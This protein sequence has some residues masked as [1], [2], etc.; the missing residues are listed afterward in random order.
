M[1]Y[2]QLKKRM[3]KINQKIIINNKILEVQQKGSHGT[4]IVILTGLGCSFDDWHEIT[5]ELSKEHRVIMFHRPGLGMSEIGDESRTTEVFV[6]E[7]KGGLGQLNIHE[8]IILVGHSYGGLCV[9][10]FAKMYPMLIKG[11]VLV[12]S[13]SVDFAMLDTL[14][15]PVLDEDNT[16][17]AWIEKCKLYSKMTTEDLRSIINPSLSEKQKQ[18]PSNIQHRLM[19]FQVNPTLYKAMGS[20]ITHWKKDAEL[21]KELESFL[22]VPL[23]VIGRDKEYC[24][25]IGVEE[26]L[27]EWELRLYEDKWEELISEQACLT[28]HSKLL[29]AK[30]SG[31]LIYLDRPDVLIKCIK[32]IEVD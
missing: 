11:I 22:D 14:K 17:E 16:D 27:P 26:G 24:I 8:P 25:R 19:E 29:Y 5:E 31:H 1:D 13:T 15:L 23:I 2:N 10:H 28:S 21:I 18:F 9:Q 3:R 4:P 7:L 6:Q 20:E 12:D 30:N 32:E